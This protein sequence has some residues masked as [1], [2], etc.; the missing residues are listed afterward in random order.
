MVM[1]DRPAKALPSRREAPRR[2]HEATTMIV[3][4]SPDV[5]LKLTI[6]I[7]AAH[8]EKNE[9]AIDALPDGGANLCEAAVV[10][11]QEDRARTKARRRHE[12]RRLGGPQAQSERRS[13]AAEPAEPDLH[14][15]PPPS[16]GGAGVGSPE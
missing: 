15:R 6:Q 1:D 8:V 3:T 14:S 12:R 10:A 16:G 9:V 13:K 2:Q 7:V 5:V 11:R 4:S